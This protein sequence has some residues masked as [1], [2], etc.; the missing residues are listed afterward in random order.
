MRISSVGK[1]AFSINSAGI[2]EYLHVK[3]RNQTLTFHHSQKVAQNRLKTKHRPEIMKLL[4]EYKGLKYCD[5]GLG[6]DFL[7]MTPKAQAAK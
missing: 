5:I 6:D 2:V 7:A 3:Q 4:E 1:T